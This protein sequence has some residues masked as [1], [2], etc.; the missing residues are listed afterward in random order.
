MPP[1]R[2]RRST[3]L[4]RRE[5]T[6]RIKGG[7]AVAADLVRYVEKCADKV[8]DASGIDEVAKN[9]EEIKSDVVDAENRDEKINTKEIAADVKAEEVRAKKIIETLPDAISLK[10]RTA[11]LRKIEKIL[12]GKIRD[13]IPAID[14]LIHAMD[15]AHKKEI[16]NINNMF[17][18][19]DLKIK[20]ST[21]RLWRYK[22]SLEDEY[23]K[24]KKWI[25]TAR[26]T[27][28]DAIKDKDPDEYIKLAISSVNISD[29]VSEILKFALSVLYR[30]LIISAIIYIVVGPGHIDLI[31]SLEYSLVVRLI[32][33]GIG[34]ILAGTLTMSKPFFL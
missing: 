31:T 2:S 34:A 26:K 8:V 9:L 4:R 28:V 1:R 25:T 23:I 12:S 17:N 21:V 5:A 3:S 11:I 16:A 20:N 29:Y 22:N 15:G 24:N 10:D 13:I 33:T 19:G 30:A 32:W 6:R 18:D 14:T 7:A 27:I